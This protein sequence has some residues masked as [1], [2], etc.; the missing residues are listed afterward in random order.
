MGH[1]FL[2]NALK[3]ALVLG[4]L[5]LA[6]C[7]GG[8]GAPT[9]PPPAGP[10]ADL[11]VAKVDG[12]PSQWNARDNFTVSVTVR[13]QGE[14]RAGAFLVGLYASVDPIITT[15]DE[16][17]GSSPT[18]DVLE[19]GGSLIVRIGVSPLSVPSGLVSQGVEY[20]DRGNYYLGAIAD[21][22]GEVDE[23]DEEN[24]DDHARNNPPPAVRFDP[25]PL[26][27]GGV[28]TGAISEGTASTS[29]TATAT[30]GDGVV[31][32]AFRTEVSPTTGSYGSLTITTAGVW[33]YT[34]DNSAGGATDR[35][36]GGATETDA[37]TI[38]AADRTEATVTI[39]ITGVNDAATF[40]GTQTGAVTEDAT[41]N[42][43]TGSIT[44]SDVDG[45]NA[46]KEQA[47]Q[48]GSYGSLSVNHSTGVWTYTLTNSGDN[49]QARATQALAGGATA[50]EAFTILAADDTPTTLTI[51][52]TGVNDAATIGGMLTGAIT[53]D[54]APNTTTGTVTS[55]DVDG[56]DNAFKAEVSPTTGTYGSLTI[57]TAGV[58]TYTLD[59]SAGGATDRLAGGATETDAFTIMAA[60]R[61]EATVT[62]TITGVNDAAT[63]SGTQT[64]AVTE[65]ATVN[66]AT[67]SITVSDVDGDNALKEQADQTGS[68]GSLSV[69]H[70][71]GVWTYT[72]TNSGDNDQARATQAL[73]GGATATEAFTILAA[74]DTPTTL[75][76]TITGVN[77]AATIGGM[78]TGA[79]TE[80]AA[81]NTTTGT[82][83]ST[84]VDGTDNA[85][86]AEVSPTTGTYGSLTITTAGAW[87]Y[88][89]NNSAGGA[90]DLL[91]GNEDP[92][93]TDAFTIMAADGTEATVT[94]TIT[95]VNDAATI[96][97]AVTGAIT[98]GTAS[99]TRTVTSTDPDGTDDAFKT[100]VSP[101]T[102]TYGSLTITNAGAWTYTLNNSA[103]G[104]T[105]L[106]DGNEDPKETDAFTIMAADGT[107]ATVTITI[108]G[109]ND[110]A[111][112]GGAV[113]GAITEGTVS[114]TG[115]VTS[116]DPDGTDDAFKTEVSPNNGTTLT[117]GTS[118]YG[119]LT[120]TTA[121]VWTYT[122]DNSSGGA[123]DL[124]AGGATATDAFTIMAADGTTGMVTITITGVDDDATIGGDLTGY[125]KGYFK[126]S[127]TGTATYTGTDPFREQSGQKY[128][129][130]LFS[131][132]VNG[133]WRYA[134]NNDDP[135][136]RALGQDEQA[137][138]TITIIATDNTTATITITIAGSG[139]AERVLRLTPRDGSLDVNWTAA[140]IA[141]GGYRVR[142]RTVEPRGSLTPQDVS[143]GT[144]SYTITG[145]TNGTRYFVR[146]DPLIGEYVY[147]GNTV[148]GEATPTATTTIDGD[149]M[150]TVTKGDGT[151]TRAATIRGAPPPPS[152]RRYRRTMAR[153]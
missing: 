13:N 132:D 136:T 33:T 69:N 52:I 53:E 57:T 77:D 86:K 61:T 123:T 101:T 80:D 143:A 84:D 15:D 97:G 11:R 127:A 12:L 85:F 17:I 76:I 25:S 1:F 30:D 22:D 107:E 60:D 63:F 96:G 116:T 115:T 70:S 64:G 81:P 68:Y 106:L 49:D 74:D 18:S 62:I 40:S 56:T 88:T 128:T 36:A 79:I 122:L 110:A 23:T 100:E 20:L 48:T 129:Y 121:G 109:V 42:R 151:V 2:L 147:R 99:T 16:L 6:A 21:I 73:A 95:G 27:I 153:R 102:G 59:N 72:L 71:T 105:D 117:T 114:T 93:E 90:T 83:T 104:A 125:V 8:G 4:L 66:R 44:V 75:T 134:L 130:G 98:E 14:G 152:R 118:D 137:T 32:N 139:S 24:N 145:L 92:K 78:L 87:T 149:L 34:L 54:A 55:T 10:L 43:A 138:E 5:S 38:M 141:P 126:N 31:D 50:T 19:G 35:L 119:T 94:I 26:T 46:L 47:D 124:L 67:G 58:W 7:G 45:D 113:T 108:T 111:T 133:S 150:G 29:G 37:F 91:D 3:A 146:V 51:T 144:L 142:W 103:G 9:A 41:V 135:D 82:V 131:I 65:D 148:R 140:A 39:T 89:L 28:L 112:I 120:I